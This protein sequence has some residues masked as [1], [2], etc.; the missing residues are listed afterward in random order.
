MLQ[1]VL[2]SFFAYKYFNVQV[3]YNKLA[4]KFQGYTQLGFDLEK[5]IKLMSQYHEQ[6]QK[7]FNLMYL[8]MLFNQ[9]VD[10]IPRSCLHMSEKK[11]KKDF[12]I[13]DYCQN[14]QISLDPS[15]QDFQIHLNGSFFF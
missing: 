9:N 5:Q 4:I 7:K 11:Y 1:I 14:Y 6:A 15:Y 12:E 13:I 10:L 8:D 3:S 2:S